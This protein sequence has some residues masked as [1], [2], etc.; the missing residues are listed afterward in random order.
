MDT[1]KFASHALCPYV[2]RFAIALEEKGIPFKRFYI[3]QARMDSR[4]VA[5]RQVLLLKT[6]PFIFAA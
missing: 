6:R 2:Q 5:S 1:L 3:E 4:A